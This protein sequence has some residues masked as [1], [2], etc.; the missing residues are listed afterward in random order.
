MGACAITGIQHNLVARASVTFI[1]VAVQKYRGLWERDCIQH[2]DVVVFRTLRFHSSTR[3]QQNGVFKN[4][5]SGERFRKNAFSVTAFTGEK[6]LRFQT[7]T[8]TCEQ[9]LY[10]RYYTQFC[11]ST[12]SHV[13]QI[14]F[15][16]CDEV[17]ISLGPRTVFLMQ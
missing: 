8:D 14:S 15:N 5:H 17:I 10:L 3:V 11:K 1:P 16:Q 7:K 12:L 13:P 6:Y 9:G 2:Q 4:L